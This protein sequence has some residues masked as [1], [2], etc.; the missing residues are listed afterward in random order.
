MQIS[1]KPNTL[2]P[3]S[4]KG[5]RRLS[6]WDNIIWKMKKK[7]NAPHPLFL[8]TLF[9]PEGKIPKVCKGKRD[10][11]ILFILLHRFCRGWGLGSSP[12]SPLQE[13]AE[14]HLWALQGEASQEI[15]GPRKGWLLP[16][17][18]ARP[19]KAARGTERVQEASSK[20]PL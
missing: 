16:G 11:T 18:G 15:Q 10:S 12:S 7:P 9:K 5:K 3:K 1:E 20:S 4:E 8:P 14:P 6:G 2:S 17:G 13:E 19:G